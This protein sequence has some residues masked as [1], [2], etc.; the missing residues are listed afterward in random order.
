M[1]NGKMTYN[2][3]LELKNGIL[4]INIIYYRSDGSKY[5][6]NFSESLKHGTGKYISPSFTYDGNWMNGKMEG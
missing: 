3:D 5:E 4:W 1:D 6:G 2:K